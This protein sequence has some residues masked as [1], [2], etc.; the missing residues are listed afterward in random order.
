MEAEWHPH[1]RFVW[2]AIYIVLEE[3]WLTPKRFSV[4]AP[5]SRKAPIGTIW[6]ICSAFL[7]LLIVVGVP[8]IDPNATVI[9]ESSPDLVEDHKQMTDVL[10]GMRFVTQFP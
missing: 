10:V 2:D 8:E 9:L 4:S 7:A 3:L 6:C 5:S 1:L